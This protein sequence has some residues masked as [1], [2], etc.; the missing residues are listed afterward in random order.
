M[1][2]E[3][4]DI[5]FDN[6]PPVED[7]D[8]PGCVALFRAVL[9][10]A[11]HDS[12][13]SLV[14][15]KTKCDPLETA[16]AAWLWLHSDEGPNL[17]AR[18]QVS[19]HAGYDPEAFDIQIARADIPWPTPET[20]SNPTLILERAHWKMN[21]CVGPEPLLG[22]YAEPRRKRATTRA[23]RREEVRSYILRTRFDAR[24]TGNGRR[25]SIKP[26]PVAA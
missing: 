19:E 10:R 22:L 18:Q 21:G 25:A 23:G 20:L 13:G 24:V 7:H 17:M 4:T 15:P 1:Q 9:L 2:D 5:A 12:C 14:T 11:F 16:R 8:L 6:F 3:Q 26:E